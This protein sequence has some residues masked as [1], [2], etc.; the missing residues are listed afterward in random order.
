VNAKSILSSLVCFGLVLAAALACPRAQAY[1]EPNILQRDWQ[2]E[3]TYRTPKPISVKNTQGVIEW[4]WYMPY[5]VVNNTGEERLFIPSIT[6][7]TEEGDIISAGKGVPAIVFV[8]IKAELGNSLLQSP[9]QV[10]GK[11][12]TGEDF[13]KESVAIWPAF[14]HDISRMSIFIGG[15]SGETHEEHNPVT[16]DK[17]LM[18]K[19][20][21]INLEFPGKPTSPQ[22][23]AVVPKGDQWIVR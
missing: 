17:V 6:I 4:Y 13:A 21:M 22:V 23:Q 5:K 20:F 3:F 12:L 14:K 11:F 16:G 8:K 10:V 1:P 19:T 2:Y 15:I 9:A 18:N 7:A